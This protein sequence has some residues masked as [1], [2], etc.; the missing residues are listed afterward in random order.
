MKAASTPRLGTRAEAE[1]RTRAQQETL[2]GFQ[3]PWVVG[4]WTDDGVICV[5]V[6]QAIFVVRHFIAVDGT[7]LSSERFHAG[8]H[9]REARRFL[10][11]GRVS[12]WY[13]LLPRLKTHP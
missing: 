12:E 3:Q 6:Y 10:L 5:Y 9:D 11:A 2:N 4:S 8:D 7:V 1:P 13:E